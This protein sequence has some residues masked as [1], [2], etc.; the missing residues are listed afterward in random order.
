MPYKDPEKRKACYE[1]WAEEN[2]K[3]R[4]EY[5][6]EWAE[7]NKEKRAEYHKEWAKKNKEKRAAYYKQWAEENKEHRQEYN[8]QFSTQNAEYIKKRLETDPLFRLQH[9]I[10]CLIGGSLKNKGYKKNSKTEKILGCTI[11][12]FKEHLESLFKEGMTWENR[13][14]WEIDHKIPASSA[15]TE[16]DAIK[17][18]HY[19][20]LQPLWTEDN[21]K[22]SDKLDYL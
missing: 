7:E 18:N 3:E 16:A 12:E 8:K 21:R 2:K 22:K 1:K 15:K 13:N 14:E 11:P 5:H 10:R 4:A 19:T 9:Q 17:L 6:K 20:N